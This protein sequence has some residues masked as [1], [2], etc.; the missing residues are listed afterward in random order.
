MNPRRHTAVIY[1]RVSSEAQVDGTSLATQREA[2]RA[3]AAR[4]GLSV[5][6]E[7]EDAGKSAKSVVGRDA[8][9]AAVDAAVHAKAALVVYKF[10]RLSRNLGDGYELRDLLAAK[11]CRI[12]S[13][14]EGEATTTPVSKA[15]YAMMMAF[16]EL[17]NDIRAERCRSGMRARAMQGGWSSSPPAGFALSRNAAGVPVLVPDG[18]RAELLRSAFIDFADGRIDKAALIGRIKQAGYPDSTA[19]RIIRNPA[20]GGIIRNALTEGDDVPAAFPGL[21]TPDQWYIIE[22]RLGGPSFERQSDNPAFP[23]TGTV[24]CSICGRPL[25]SGFSRGRGGTYGYYFCREAG[26]PKISAGELHAQANAM[27][28][29]LGTVKPFLE[30]LKKAVAKRELTDPHS[31]ERQRRQRDIIRAE[32]QLQRLRSALLD[33]IFTRDEYDAEKLRINATLSEAR[34]WLADHADA[35]DRRAACIDL[36]IGIF[37]DPAALLSKLTVPQT[38]DLIRIVFNRFTLTSDKKIEPSQDSV[39][40]VLTTA[41][42]SS[43]LDGRPCESKI[44]QITMAICRMSESLAS[45]LG[46][47]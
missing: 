6:S 32:S 36:L 35:A 16:A 45:L 14:T 24:I 38:K 17:D 9:T 7:H 10:D 3:A 37:S 28:A 27:L 20:Y 1:V 11:G 12:I 8:L 25:R 23:F 30:M 31:E 33:G 46:A 19:S 2:C 29:R 21:V 34:R 22:A 26:H 44:E 47:A 40:T 4:L 15:L 41:Q 42:S 39:F 5:L 18:D 13:A 43:F